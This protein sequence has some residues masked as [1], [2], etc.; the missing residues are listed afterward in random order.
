MNV[1][2]LVGGSVPYFG[3]PA[4][5]WGRR[6]RGAPTD[7]GERLPRANRVGWSQE[8]FR[9]EQRA[10]AEIAEIPGGQHRKSAPHRE[11][12]SGRVQPLDDIEH[13]ALR[14][15]LRVQW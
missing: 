1:N 5:D 9:I 11:L 14:V 2:R 10:F 3:T 8:Q 15:A 12:Q 13:L 6:C 4:G 7:G